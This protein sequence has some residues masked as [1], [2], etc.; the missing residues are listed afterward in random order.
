MQQQYDC[1]K[2]RFHTPLH[3]SRG[4]EQYDEGATTLH[5]D[6]LV[7]ALFSAACRLGVEAEEVLSMLDS[8]RI[9]SAFPFY[10]EEYFF[11]K[12]MTAL[13]FKLSD[14][15]KEK[16]GKPFKKIRFLGKDWFEK[17]LF[18][19]EEQ[20]QARTH[21]QQPAFLTDKPIGT[22]FKREV[23]QRVTIAPDYSEDAKPFYTE[24]LY[25]AEDAGLFVLV[26]WLDESAK[27]LFQ[28]AFRLLGDLGVG[29]DRSVGNGFFTPSFGSLSLSMPDQASNQCALGLYLPHESEI[30][31]DF[32]EKSAWGLVKRGGFLAGAANEE[33]ITLRKKSVYMFDVGSVFPN[34]PLKGKRVDLKPDWQGL[35]HPVWREGRP[36]FVPIVKYI[37][38]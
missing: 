33:H 18:A 32:L 19:E 7:A 30:Q 13:P 21:L 34:T 31:E 28:N 38:S 8:F 29:T 26:Q 15:D 11:P 23:V 35:N 10:G 37:T 6:T 1:I 36:V 20:I 24:R 22:V 12:P 5:S 3:L 2:L 16:Q 14:L 25:F 9:S 27:P 17:I 4:R